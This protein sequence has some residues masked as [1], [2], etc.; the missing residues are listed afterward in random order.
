M[1]QIANLR[2]KYISF[3]K[4]CCVH[5]V[6]F[7]G[8]KEGRDKSFPL[9]STPTKKDESQTFLKSEK[10]KEKKVP[11]AVP[12]L[13]FPKSSRRKISSLRGEDEMRERERASA[14]SLLG[15]IYLAHHN[16]REKK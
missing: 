15:E 2:G 8:K 11:Q 7:A 13:Y 3:H 5:E 10:R 16:F 14:D 4:D 12:L 9:L 6:N 1:E